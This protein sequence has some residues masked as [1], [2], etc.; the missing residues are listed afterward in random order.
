LRQRARAIAL[1]RAFTAA[2][3]LRLGLAPA[4]LP[5]LNP[6]QRHLTR[7]DVGNAPST[8]FV[9][10]PCRSLGWSFDNTA[11]ELAETE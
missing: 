4:D 3:L 7:T 6:A 8:N 10:P 5:S 1:S 11:E 2:L 9:A